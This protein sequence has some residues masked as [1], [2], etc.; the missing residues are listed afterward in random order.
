MTSGDDITTAT[1]QTFL[2]KLMGTNNAR[3]NEMGAAIKRHQEDFNSVHTRFVNV[4][5]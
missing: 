3:F 2:T 5:N 1:M 4:E